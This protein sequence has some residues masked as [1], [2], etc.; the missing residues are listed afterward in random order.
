MSRGSLPKDYAGSGKKK[1]WKYELA[2][3]AIGMGL[4]FS[5]I[6]GSLLAYD[7]ITKGATTMAQGL[8]PFTIITSIISP[9]AFVFVWKKYRALEQ[10]QPSGLTKL[11]YRDRAEKQCTICQKHPVSKKHHI[12]SEHKMKNVNVNDYFRDCGCDICAHYDQS[13]G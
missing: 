9:I 6:I 2:F 4:L 3:V 13:G 5:G 1:L 12:E 11:Y 10:E 7:F 8:I